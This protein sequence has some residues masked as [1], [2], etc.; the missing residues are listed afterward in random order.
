MEMSLMSHSRKGQLICFVGIDGS[1]K[2]SNAL[3]LLNRLK[4]EKRSCKYVYG[5]WSPVLSYPFL[6]FLRL[7]GYSKRV[8]KG[9]RTYLERYYS[10]NKPVSMVWL[11]FVWIDVTIRT[12]LGV[13]FPLRRGK[14]VVCD[15]YVYDVMVDAMADVHDSSAMWKIPLRFVLATT[16]KPNVVFFMD[17]PESRAF[18]RKEDTPNMEYLQVRRRLFRKMAKDFAFVEIDS[19]KPPNENQET[20]LQTLCPFLEK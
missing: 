7:V 8:E 20:I 1:G 4:M 17:V 14:I 19:T 10:R 9:N 6:A 11:F 2:T 5:R 15:R 16:P 12:A 18:A 13:L 3:K